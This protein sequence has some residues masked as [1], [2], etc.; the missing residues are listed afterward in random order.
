LTGSLSN[1]GAVSLQNGATLTASGA[2]NNIGTGSFQVDASGSGGSSLNIAGTLTNSASGG[3]FGGLFIGNSAISQATTITA[4]GLSNTGDIG[5]TGSATKQAALEIG[6]AAPS[7]W[8]GRLF[9]SGDALLQF[10]G[11]GQIGT[12]GSGAEMDITGPQAYVAAAGINST[13]NS[14]LRGLTTNN[15]RFSVAS[16]ASVATSGGLSNAGTLSVDGGGSLNVAGI[17]SNSAG[18]FSGVTIGHPGV[19]QPTTVTAGGLVN[20][21]TFNIES[22]TGTATVIS[23]TLSNT[24]EISISGST[25]QA[26]LEIGSA[27]PAT[28]TGTALLQGN[29]LL[30]FAGTSQ[31][32]TIGNNASVELDSPQAFVSAAGINSTSN[33][34]LAGLTMIASGGGLLVENGASVTTNGGLTV[35]GRI[36]SGPNGSLTVSGGLT[37]TTLDITGTLT[38]GGF[39]AISACGSNCTAT[40][41]VKAAALDNTGTVEIG[42][43]PTSLALLQLGTGI[44]SIASGA[45]LTLSGPN[46]QV[47]L[48]GKPTNNSGLVNL[49]SNA[50]T[51][52]LNSGGAAGATVTTSTGFTNTGSVVLDVGCCPAAG[53]STFNIGGVLTNSG[54]I[55]IGQGTF[56]GNSASSNVTATGLVNTGNIDIEGAAFTDNLTISGPASNSGTG[57]VNIGVS[58]NLNVTGAGNTYLQAGSGQTIVQGTLTAP[59]ISVTGGNLTLQKVP[60]FPGSGTVV[61]NV[62]VTGGTLL[63]HGIVTG[64]LNISSTGTIKV[65]D[66]VNNNSPQTLVING[67]YAQSGGT[68][69]ELLQGTGVQNYEVNVT[70]GHSVT[71]TGGDLQPF[72]VTFALGQEFDDIMTFQPG[73]LTGTFATILGGGNGTTRDLGNGLTLEA[74]YDNAGGDISLRVIPTTVGNTITWNDATGNWTTDTTKWTPTGPPQPFQDVIIGSTNNGNVT[75]DHPAATTINSLTINPS[76]ALTTTSGTT[77]TISTTVAN[78]GSLTLGGNLTALGAFTNNSGAALTM[79]GGTLSAASLRNAG[80]TSGFGTITPL[81]ANTGLVQ[82][83]GGTL[84]AQN[85]I[86]GT[87]N[88]TVNPVATLDLSRATTA[89][90]AGALNVNGSLNLGSQNLVVAADYN[91]ANFGTGNSFAKNANVAG[92]GQILAAGPNTSNMQ[93]VTGPKVTGGNTTTPVLDLGIVHIGDSTTYQ[94]ANQGTAAN[95]LL[96]GAIQTNNGGNID[97]NLLTGT[98]VTP[99]NFGPIAPSGSSTFTVTAVGAGLLGGQAVHIANNFGDVPEQTMG[100]AGQVNLFAALAFLKEG[101]DGTLS[102]GFVLD[103]GNVAQGSSQ[104]A[105][106]A[107][108]NDNPLADQAFTDL[109]STAG[110]GTMGPFRLAGCSVKDLPGGDQ[111]GGCDAFFDTSGLGDF[112]EMFSFPVESSNSSGFDEVIGTVTLT[113]EGSVGPQ[114]PPQAPEP[115]TISVLGSGLAML[116]FIHGR[117]RRTG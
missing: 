11:T 34:A 63:G 95:P 24:G 1:S 16:G 31:I 4:A 92:T 43:G 49:S 14:A 46:A 47:Q 54:R 65:S 27:A 52:N 38:S 78:S 75:L 55:G 88:V 50:G 23:P 12:I 116:F 69:S 85:G 8:T 114:P 48:I 61:G 39:V 101:G 41:M 97:P 53:G 33:S 89:S 70:S 6:A 109:L 2:L 10:S 56:N 79:Q 36:G 7:T 67:N 82:A 64:N 40:T 42:G 94:V 18:G 108:L 59:S 77:L 84:T 96:R 29:A 26:A 102:D 72:G 117:R 107:I 3:G 83:N 91:N 58:S 100:I 104:E 66:L 81:I 110:D 13:S 45:T 115:G 28:W 113:L 68:F 37:G 25:A 80:T 87:G 51:F 98:G 17:L 44:T 30:Q 5:I 22:G 19:A 111:Q 35:S 86:Q 93:V 105:L 15:G 62:N 60:S 57:E 21:G 20:T 9:L 76:N 73:E 90:S 103:F 106:L 71:L 74:I 32:G 99:A 112:K